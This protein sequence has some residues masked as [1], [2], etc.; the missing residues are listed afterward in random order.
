[1]WDLDANRGSTHKHIN[2][3]GPIKY[4][5]IQYLSAISLASLRL[6]AAKISKTACISNKWSKMTFCDDYSYATLM[7]TSECTQ[8]CT[9]ENHANLLAYLTNWLLFTPENGSQGA[10]KC[11]G[12]AFLGFAQVFSALIVRKNCKNGLLLKHSYVYC[13]LLINYVCGAH[14]QST[15]AQFSPLYPSLYPYV[16]W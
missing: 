3:S 4:H 8:T 5:A 14:R 10:I 16:T 9:F 1:M 11:Q 12:V 2:T 6:H 15:Y 13:R 7:Y